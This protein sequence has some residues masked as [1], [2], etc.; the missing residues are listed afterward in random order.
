VKAPELTATPLPAISERLGLPYI[1]LLP[2]LRAQPPR[3][4][5]KLYL[6]EDKHWS[7]DGHEKAARF[8]AGE[9]DR[10]SLIPKTVAER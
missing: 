8:V 2:T 6:R 7:D 4:R 3:E 10:R 1:D 5:D 9:F